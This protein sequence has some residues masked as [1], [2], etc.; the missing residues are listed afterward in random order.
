MSRYDEEQAILL[1]NHGNVKTNIRKVY[2]SSNEYVKDILSGFDLNDKSVLSVAGSCDQ[3]IVMVNN[4]VKYLDLFDINRLTKYYYYLRRW[5]MDYYNKIYPDRFDM[6]DRI[7]NLSRIVDVNSEEEV[8]I[9]RFWEGISAYLTNDNFY[10]FFYDGLKFLDSND[11]VKNFRV[12]N[13]YNFDISGNVNLDKKYDVIYTSNIIDYVKKFEIY[14]DNLYELLNQDGI[15]ICSN[16]F[17]G[18]VSDNAKKIFEKKFD[19][20]DIVSSKYNNCKVGSCFIKR[21]CI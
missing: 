10:S 8:D 12:D 16:V 20:K 6:G 9:V 14:R 7:F 1:F 11:I 21:R 5:Y 2:Y 18:H 3:A 4:G 17:G 13:F 15:V 19:Y